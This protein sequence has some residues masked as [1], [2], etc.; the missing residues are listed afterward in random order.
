MAGPVSR[1]AKA[2]PSSSQKSR[3]LGTT[4]EVSVCLV[5]R[6]MVLHSSGVSLESVMRPPVS[7]DQGTAQARLGAGAEGNSMLMTGLSGN[8]KT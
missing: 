1:M 6:G 2:A 3:T 5:E 8:G 4:S 7:T